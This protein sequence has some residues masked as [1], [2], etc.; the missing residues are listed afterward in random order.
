M[1][2]IYKEFVFFTD[3]DAYQFENQTINLKI[4]MLVHRFCAPPPVTK[5]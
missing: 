4:N 5:Q 3:T 1:S 2:L